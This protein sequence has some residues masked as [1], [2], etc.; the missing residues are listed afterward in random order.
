[1]HELAIVQTLVHLIETHVAE[2]QATKVLKVKVKIGKL[3][4]IEEHL[5]KLAFDTFKENTV[6]QD[7][8]LV[9]AMEPIS[10]RCNQCKTEGILEKFWFQCPSC[11]SLDIT[12]VGG[13]EMLL[14][15]LELE[16]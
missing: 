11:N 14:E 5:L 8:E 3:S 4:G 16:K 12:V 13:E 2:Y 7:A 10:I 9:I 6:A 15:S 1:M